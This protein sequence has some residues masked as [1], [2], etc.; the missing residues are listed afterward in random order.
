MVNVSFQLRFERFHRT[1]KV[2]V[3]AVAVKDS[4]YGYPKEGPLGS[5]GKIAVNSVTGELSAHTPIED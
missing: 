5:V 1:A 2:R 4:L 3:V